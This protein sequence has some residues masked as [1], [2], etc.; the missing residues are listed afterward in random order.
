[1]RHHMKSQHKMVGPISQRPGSWTPD[2]V[3]GCE[4]PRKDIYANLL[5]STNMHDRVVRNGG[6]ALL[7]T[8]SFPNF[9]E[10][11]S[12]QSSAT[13]CTEEIDP[14]SPASAV[15][16]PETREAT[17]V[18]SS[19]SLSL[20][21]IKK[22]KVAGKRTSFKSEELV[23]SGNRAYDGTPGSSSR[24]TLPKVLSSRVKGGLKGTKRKTE[25]GRGGVKVEKTL[26]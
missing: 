11:R 5:P 17:V 8:Q 3:D 16:L 9:M 24:K 18:M 22:K 7:V 21:G 26:V 2:H 15:I 6:E 4:I 10:S 1:M 14:V 23:E 19:K 20:R 25:T 13:I 12:P